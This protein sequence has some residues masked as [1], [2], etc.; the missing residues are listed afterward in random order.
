MVKRRLVLQIATGTLRAELLVRGKPD[1]V[2]ESTFANEE[3]LEEAIAQL[4]TE[5]PE[6]RRILTDIVLAP[7]LAQ[8]RKHVDLPPVRRERMLERIVA[9][10]S[11]RFFR[12]NGHPLT[13][14]VCRSRRRWWSRR[15]VQVEVRAAAVEQ[16][17]LDAIG[18]GL[19]SAGLVEHSI[20]VSTSPDGPRFRS[21]QFHR[22]RIRSVGRQ[23]RLFLILALLSWVMAA[24]VAGL[25]FRQTA[26]TLRSEIERL[27]APA[28]AAANARR[29]LDQARAALDSVAAA[30]RST[31]QAL[32]AVAT[33]T[34]AI[35][36]SAFLASLEWNENGGSLTGAARHAVDVVA[37]LE[38]AG[39][40]QPRLEGTPVSERTDAGSRERFVI[41]FGPAGVEAP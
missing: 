19:E 23:T 33:L 37:G 18:T 21:P 14:A 1:W 30:R 3:D 26:M 27:R 32:E 4:A 34:T 5:L 15:P 6:H 39:V 8:L 25:R 10:Q 22:T 16:R 28:A 36:D 40:I 11:N 24:A 31:A 13:T 12:R 38:H 20:A 7:P 9:T 2:A 29:A 41:R 35:P 17:W